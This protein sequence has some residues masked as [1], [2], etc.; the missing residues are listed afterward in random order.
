M[1][2]STKTTAAPAADP[3]VEAEKLS[4]P[5]TP[6][7]PSAAVTIDGTAIETGT[8]ATIG[9]NQPTGELPTTASVHDQ[10]VATI[11]T[12]NSAIERVDSINQRMAYLIM[13]RHIVL[14]HLKPDTASL[15]ICAESKAHFDQLHEALVDEFYPD[16]LTSAKTL[17]NAGKGLKRSTFRTR[18]RTS[19]RLACDLAWDGVT[20]EA[21]DHDRSAFGLHPLLWCPP[22]FTP[23]NE[24]LGVIQGDRFIPISVRYMAADDDTQMFYMNRPRMASIGFNLSMRQYQYAGLYRRLAAKARQDNAPQPAAEGTPGRQTRA[25]GVPGGD[26]RNSTVKAQAEADKLAAEARAAELAAATAKA[27][28]SAADATVKESELKEAQAIASLTETELG[29]T[30]TTAEAQSNLAALTAKVNAI[31]EA[32]DIVFNNDQIGL[33]GWANL[34]TKAINGTASFISV[35]DRWK[36]DDAPD[37]ARPVK[38]ATA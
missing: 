2:K 30:A 32:M 22:D 11:A 3:I 12:L 34:T 18:V 6:Q 8:V 16:A 21:Y 15:R 24:Y 38:A 10:M 29:T 35:Y 9:H 33:V 28:A 25:G 37:T 27:K 7:A 17:D 20:H 4:Q 1:A 14:T 13:L 26:E 19:L 36:G 5:V 23:Q 31:C